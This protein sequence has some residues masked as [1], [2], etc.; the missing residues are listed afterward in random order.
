MTVTTTHA[1]MNYNT[2]GVVTIFP[3][4]F[5]FRT[6]TDLKVYK[7]SSLGVVTLAALN[8][9]YTVTIDVGLTGEVIFL[10]PPANFGRVVIIR[11]NPVVQGTSSIGVE[12]FSAGQVEVISDQEL[13]VIQELVDKVARVPQLGTTDINGFGAYDAAQNR[14]KNVADPIDD[15][16]AVNKNWALGNLQGAPGIPGTPGS[17]GIT[18]TQGSAATEWIINHNLG[19][20]PSASIFT[21]GGVRVEAEILHISVNQLRVYFAAIMA[22]SVYVI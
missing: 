10:S 12:E 13:F 19:Y 16:D 1:R 5:K 18:F 4:T 6:S 20:R 14:I 2:N 7:V 11:Q 17:T 3:V 21:T 22:G 8:T 9:D 15:D